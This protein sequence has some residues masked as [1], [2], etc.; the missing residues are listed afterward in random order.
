MKRTA[1]KLS[2]REAQICTLLAGELSQKQIAGQL[3]ISPSAVRGFLQ[4]A[5]FKSGTRT[6]IGLVLW[7]VKSC[8]ENATRK[9]QQ[10]GAARKRRM[11]A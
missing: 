5:M 1:P 7:W 11:A 3:G 8:S 9:T 4:R 2:P 10:D 6:V